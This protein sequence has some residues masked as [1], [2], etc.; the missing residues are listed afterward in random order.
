MNKWKNV[1]IILFFI[2]SKKRFNKF[3]MHKKVFL[4]VLKAENCVQE[5]LCDL[6]Y[7]NF[8]PNN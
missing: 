4:V 3:I 7:N 8:L 6:C 1:N 2:K 5:W